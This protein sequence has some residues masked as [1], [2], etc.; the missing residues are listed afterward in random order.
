MAR[1]SPSL[2]ARAL[3]FLAAR[4]HSRLELEQKLARHSD[5]AQ[6]IAA[7]LDDLTAK[8]FISEQRV[9]ESLL[10]QRAPKLGTA[11]LLQELRRKGLSDAV[12]AAAAE[13]LRS[14]ELE[15]AQAVWQKKYGQSPADPRERARQMRFMAARGFAADVVRRVVPRG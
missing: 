6:A 3:R 14:T 10:Y 13:Q 2:K 1:Q 8:G 11:R 5:D 9:A 7:A 15:R 4:E 12:V